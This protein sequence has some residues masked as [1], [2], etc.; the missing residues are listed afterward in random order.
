MTP[1]WIMLTLPPSN[2]GG[3]QPPPYRNPTA[4]AGENGGRWRAGGGWECGWLTRPLPNG[5]F[6]AQ[7]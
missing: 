4:Y 7:R 5:R 2:H 6:E 3:G 1:T